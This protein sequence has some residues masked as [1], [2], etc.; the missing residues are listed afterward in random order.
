MYRDLDSARKGVGFSPQN[1]N[2]V[3]EIGAVAIE[4]QSIVKDR[5]LKTLPAIKIF[6]FEANN[7]YNRFK[8]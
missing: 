8:L 6:T 5:N 7:V 4:E 1:G 2:R 3:I